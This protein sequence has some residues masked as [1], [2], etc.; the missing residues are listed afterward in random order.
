MADREIGLLEWL[1][2]GALGSFIAA[3]F[4]RE[5]GWIEMGLCV[6]CGT[7]CA[8]FIGPYVA[9]LLSMS[10]NGKA[11]LG[12]VTGLTGMFLVGGFINAAREF[13]RNPWG[14]W[15]RLRGRGGP[16]NP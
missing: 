4:W 7:T 16:T 6:A 11:A 10:S 9:E 8:Y 13:Q 2:S 15:D 14:I 1:W 5:K 12:F 3:A